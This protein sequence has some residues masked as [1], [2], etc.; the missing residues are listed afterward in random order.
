MS[1][2]KASFM[3]V[4]A[5]VDQHRPTHR[6]L[7]GY[8]TNEILCLLF[9]LALAVRARGSI[10]PRSSSTVVAA[11]SSII[12]WSVRC[13]QH[14]KIYSLVF[15]PTESQA[16]MNQQFK[17]CHWCKK[18]GF[19]DHTPVTHQSHILP[20]AGRNCPDTQ[21]SLFSTHQNFANAVFVLVE[22]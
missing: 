18:L 3:S 22:L 13:L 6:S 12:M 14:Q 9:L 1:W 8:L 2:F 20:R 15:N 11:V 10:C 21:N 7:A 16:L 19:T 5:F 17:A 4:S